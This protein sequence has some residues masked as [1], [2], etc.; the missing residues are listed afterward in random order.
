MWF[1][2][3]PKRSGGLQEG[4]SIIPY[5]S[6]VSHKG[7]RVSQWGLRVSQRGLRISWRGHMGFKRI[8]QHSTDQTEGLTASQRG[9]TVSKRGLGTSQRVPSTSKRG[10]GLHKK[11]ILL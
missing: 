6:E 9:P 3:R 4:V 8:P 5:R 2:Q 1:H 10:H 7:L 11:L